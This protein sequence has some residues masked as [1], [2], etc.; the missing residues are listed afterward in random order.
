MF[1]FA[2][3]PKPPDGVVANGRDRVRVGCGSG[4]DCDDGSGGSQGG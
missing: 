1:R 2:A 3:A 4:V